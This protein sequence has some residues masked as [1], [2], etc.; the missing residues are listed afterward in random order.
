MKGLNKHLQLL[1]ARQQNTFQRQILIYKKLTITI[2]L[3]VW[4][5]SRLNNTQDFSNKS[6]YFA[7]VDSKLPS[8][9]SRT[10]K[11]IL[12]TNK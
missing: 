5:H 3:F 12:K 9:K 10:H 4:S 7:M 6:L 11:W 8:P 2:S 1:A